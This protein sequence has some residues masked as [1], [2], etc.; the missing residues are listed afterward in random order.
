MDLFSFFSFPTFPLRG[1][2]QSSERGKGRRLVASKV[3]NTTMS[4]PSTL[5]AAEALWKEVGEG[6]DKSL[7]GK[8]Q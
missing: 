2:F 8:K 6:L 1:L 3:C 7:Q 4:E 5:A